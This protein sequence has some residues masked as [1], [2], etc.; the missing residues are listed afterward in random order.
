LCRR[1]PRDF[2]YTLSRSK[3]VCDISTMSQMADDTESVKSAK[4]GNSTLNRQVN[5]NDTS[6]RGS[7]SS[8]VVRNRTILG[9]FPLFYKLSQSLSS[10]NTTTTL[11]TGTTS[12]AMRCSSFQIDLTQITLGLNDQDLR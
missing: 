2:G 5:Y 7:K 3:S 9:S 4:V 11:G 1:R 10:L 6:S 8:R 12:S